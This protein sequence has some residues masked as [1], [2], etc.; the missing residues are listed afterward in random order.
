MEQAYQQLEHYDGPYGILSETSS[1][2]QTL[3]NWNRVSGGIQA[4]YFKDP[5]GHNLELIHFPDSKG[6]DEWHQFASTSPLF[7]GIDHTAIVIA[8]TI[9]SRAFYCDLLGLTL[10][11][12]S[13]NLGLEQERLSDVAKVRVYISSLSLMVDIL[14]RS[15]L[16]PMICGFGK[17][18]SLLK[19]LQLRFSVYKPTSSP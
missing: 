16:V 18:P 17:R 6:K 19:I 15:I 1:S 10:K 12:E 14:F 8:N 2:P 11:Q 3:P 5:D 13:R 9:V 4:F 7:L